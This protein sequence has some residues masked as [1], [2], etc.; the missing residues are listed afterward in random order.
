VVSQKVLD[1]LLALFHVLEDVLPVLSCHLGPRAVM[2]GP[3]LCH[4][5]RR[6]QP[7]L[8]MGLLG[9]LFPG[10]VVIDVLFVVELVALGIAERLTQ[11]DH[12]TNLLAYYYYT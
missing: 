8:F 4:P 5:P 9:Q 11:A 12:L 6:S 2:G 7:V 3:T 1:A 10:D